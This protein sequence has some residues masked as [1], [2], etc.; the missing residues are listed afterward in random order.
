LNTFTGYEPDI[1]EMNGQ[2]KHLLSGVATLP[3]R[4]VQ[5]SGFTLLEI[6]VAVAIAALGLVTIMHLFAMGLKSTKKTEEMTFAILHAKNLMGEIL[7]R[8]VMEEGIESGE[9]DN[10]YSWERE[11]IL[12]DMPEAGLPDHIIEKEL[13][14][15]V[16]TFRI[17]I[18]IFH[19]SRRGAILEMETLKTVFHEG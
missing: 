3:R 18:R 10:K 2:G 9:F 17:I 6:M 1:F 12:Y 19:S 5:E 14:P 4:R 16:D 8:N 13:E 7:A 11:V 15:V